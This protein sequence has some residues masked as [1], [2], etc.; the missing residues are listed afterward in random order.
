MANN[1]L[2]LENLYHKKIL[3]CISHQDDETL[4]AG[5]LLT[6]LQ[7]KADVTI[8]CFF[9]PAPRRSDAL[10]R[11]RAIQKI[12]DDMGF[13]FI[14][15]PF[16]LEKEYPPLYRFMK[17]PLDKA[18]MKN[19]PRAPIHRHVLF[20]VLEG[21]ALA[22]IR[23]IRAQI[24]FTHN[25]RGEYGHR[26]HILLHHAVKSAAKRAP[27]EALWYFGNGLEQ[28]DITITVDPES[29]R[30]MFEYYLPQW[31]GIEIY[32]FA[33]DD[34]NYILERFEENK[35]TPPPETLENEGIDNDK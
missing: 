16:A 17:S 4:F 19:W 30:K 28:S 18:R 11:V 5:G 33:L 15:Y 21:T 22:L 6:Q 7:G 23:D 24:V 12:C 8:A 32:K 31:Q 26:E 10:T 9:R 34:E 35:A 14:Q 13:K 25:E 2:N 3:F 1:M 29:K 27:V 20:R